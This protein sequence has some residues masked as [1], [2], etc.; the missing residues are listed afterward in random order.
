MKK[1]TKSQIQEAIRY[2]KARLDEATGGLTPITG[3]QFVDMIKAAKAEDVEAYSFRYRNPT[4][5]GNGTQ[6]IKI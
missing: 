1:Y 4:N 6:P 5:K 2:W 3:K